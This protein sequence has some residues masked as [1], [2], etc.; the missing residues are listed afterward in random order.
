MIYISM[1]PAKNRVCKKAAIR[2]QWG[3]CTY[4]SP[5]SS[6]TWGVIYL[7]VPP[8]PPSMKRGPP[9]READDRCIS[10]FV[11]GVEFEFESPVDFNS[12]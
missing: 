11:T 7:K 9:D 10:P 1:N 3:P 12:F 8:L 6:T 2:Q 5:Q 4:I